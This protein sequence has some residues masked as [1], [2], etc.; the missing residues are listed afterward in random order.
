MTH[1]ELIEKVAAERG[2]K[3]AEAAGVVDAVLEAIGGALAAGDSVT[4]KGLG[5][6]KIKS[7]AARD[8]RNPRTGETLKIAA[9]RKAAFSPSTTLKARLGTA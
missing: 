5:V 4:L 6:F 7:T 1:N 2:M 3:R 8:G 9:G